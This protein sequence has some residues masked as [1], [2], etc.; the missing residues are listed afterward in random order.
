MYLRVR[1]W[2]LC[3]K[4]NEIRNVFKFMK[5]MAVLEFET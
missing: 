1:W 2:V 5:E 3:P 4:T